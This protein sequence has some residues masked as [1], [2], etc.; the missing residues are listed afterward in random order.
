[1]LNRVLKTAIYSGTL[2]GLALGSMLV[3]IMAPII[4]LAETFEAP[5]RI[6]SLSE[7]IQRD[8]LTLLGAVTLALAYAFLVTLAGKFFFNDLSVIKKGTFLSLGGFLLFYGIPAL[9]QPPILPGMESCSPVTLRQ[10][11]YME[12]VIFSVLALAGYFI[13]RYWVKLQWLAVP[14]GVIILAIPFLAGI[15]N[16]L[17]GNRVPADLV[18]QFRI[19]SFGV[20]LIFW[21]LLGLLVSYFNQRFS[22]EKQ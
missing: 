21:L 11:W 2:A 8:V 4:L 9:G 13:A 10:L 7:L 6:S 20:N 3:A 17:E 12:V 16:S 1:M 19:A 15:P 5:G 14:I 22:K 18:L